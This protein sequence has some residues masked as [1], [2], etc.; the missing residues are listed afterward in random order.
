MFPI[1][2]RS[3]KAPWYLVPVPLVVIG[4]HISVRMIPAFWPSWGC[5]VAKLLVEAAQGSIEVIDSCFALMAELEFEQSERTGVSVALLR[6][7]I[8]Q[9]RSACL[10][11]ANDPFGSMFAANILLRSQLDQFLRGCFFAGP[12]TTEE[13][14][15]FWKNDEMPKRENKRLSPSKLA[16]INTNHFNW[17]PAERIS[18]IVKNSWSI[19][20]GFSH[21]GKSLLAFYMH[22]DGIR[23]SAP[24]DDYIDTVTNAVGLALVAVTVVVSLATNRNDVS[25]NER[26]D[27]WGRAAFEYLSRWIPHWA[28]P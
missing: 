16:L 28:S 27:Q 15:Y 12:A 23:P 19:L 6:S 24:D 7:S 20:S 17:N 1:G 26:V 8:D 3:P 25:M 10:L 4:L 14:K 22:E 11:I 13:F 5:G 18:N 2:Q 9:T 21:G